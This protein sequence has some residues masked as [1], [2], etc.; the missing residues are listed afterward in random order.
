MSFFETRI[1]INETVRRFMLE[2]FH[3]NEKFRHIWSATFLKPMVWKKPNW[4]RYIIFPKTWYRFIIDIFYAIWSY[5]CIKCVVQEE[6]FWLL[7]RLRIWTSNA[8]MFFFHK[9]IYISGNKHFCPFM[10]Y[11]LIC[12]LLHG[13]NATDLI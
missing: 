10:L 2:F 1:Q 12:M 7:L 8:C 3:N 5:S 4:N 9:Y 6:Q 13:S 11:V